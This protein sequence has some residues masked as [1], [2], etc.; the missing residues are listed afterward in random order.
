[1]SGDTS[2]QM[3]RTRSDYNVKL[4]LTYCLCSIGLAICE[5]LKLFFFVKVVIELLFN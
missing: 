4:D 5:E 3:S 1:L 2:V